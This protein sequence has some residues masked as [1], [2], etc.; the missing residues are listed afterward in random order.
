MG[1]LLPSPTSPRSDLTSPRETIQAA[2]AHIV[3]AVLID[4]TR[5]GEKGYY[6]FNFY[7]D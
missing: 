2:P 7:Y 4:E 6:V 1:E 3:D 5:R